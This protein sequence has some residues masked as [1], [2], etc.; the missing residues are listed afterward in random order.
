MDTQWLACGK[1]EDYFTSVSLEEKYPISETSEAYKFSLTYL[2]AL[3]EPRVKG[4][5][6]F[7]RIPRSHQRLSR[8]GQGRKPECLIW[9][10]RD[11]KIS[12]KLS[13][14]SLS[15]LTVKTVSELAPH[16]TVTHPSAPVRFSTVFTYA[17]SQNGLSW[18]RKHTYY[19]RQW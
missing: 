13:Q 19:P 18:D 5:M 8:K 10:C 7:A 11:W 1:C 15:P 14:A 9:R 6:P 3:R 17:D 16:D 4:P 12:I 2:I